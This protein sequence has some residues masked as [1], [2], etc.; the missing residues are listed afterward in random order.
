MAI[1]RIHPYVE[2]DDLDASRSFY[3]EVFGLQVGMEAPALGLQAPDLRSAQVI[4]CPR[5]FE[6]P[7]PDFGIDVGDPEVVDHAHSRVHDRGLRI[8]YPLTT[9]PWGVRRFFVEDPNG[10]VIN[11]LAH[12]PTPPERHPRHGIQADLRGV[13]R[14]PC[15]LALTTKL[16][17]ADRHIEFSVPVADRPPLRTIRVR[18]HKNA[19]GDHPHS[20][21]DPLDCGRRDRLVAGVCR[22]SHR[23][24][25][26][27]DGGPRGAAGD[28]PAA[29]DRHRRDPALSARRRGRLATAR[30]KPCTTST[31]DRPP[32]GV[33]GRRGA[34]AAR[35]IQALVAPPGDATTLTRLVDHFFLLGG[36]LFGWLAWRT[37]GDRTS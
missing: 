33:G 9:E 27:I 3:T 32:D 14:P 4:V 18:A 21:S 5:G 1:K 29:R 23:L 22:D 28:G 30:P 35:T 37:A 8:V 24:G 26:G 20:K 2:T 12:P 36:V 6:T 31:A 34:R 16:T 7:Q 17:I 15:R 11:V 13:D 10:R 19:G 25:A